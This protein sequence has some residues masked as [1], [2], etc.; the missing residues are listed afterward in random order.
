[1]NFS[2]ELSWALLTGNI[3]EEAMTEIWALSAAILGWIAMVRLVVMLG[4]AALM[5]I[6]RWRVF[7]KAGLPGRGI[8]VPF[9]NRYLMFKLGGRSGRTFLWILVPPVFFVLMIINYFNI[10]KNFWK[11]WPYGIGLTLLKIVFIPILAFDDSKYL[12]QKGT[13]K[14]IID[15]PTINTKKSTKITP[16]KKFTTKKIIKKA[17]S[18][19][20][21]SVKPT[22]KKKP[23][24]KKK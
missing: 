24:T 16:V 18:P 22:S 14:S 10:A 1:M 19:K 6:S 17:S 4:I 11:D 21:T 5:I 23:V 3:N 7:K 8:F 2:F 12:G 13:T 15:Q 9:Y 20:K